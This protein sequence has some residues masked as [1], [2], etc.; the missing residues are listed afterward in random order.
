[1]ICLHQSKLSLLRNSTSVLR[2][3]AMVSDKCDSC[4]LNCSHSSC[5]VE[6]SL[7]LLLDVV[8]SKKLDMIVSTIIYL[9]ESLKS[10]IQLLFAIIT[11][12]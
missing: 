2:S 10:V 5:R 7:R 3:L 12:V 1:M 8:L 9:G 6:F 4:L 11:K